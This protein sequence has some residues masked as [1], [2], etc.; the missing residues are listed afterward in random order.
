M[1]KNIYLSKTK[2]VSHSVISQCVYD[3]LSIPFCVWVGGVR[4]GQSELFVDTMGIIGRWEYG[5]KEH[6]SKMRQVMASEGLD[7]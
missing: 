1:E 5:K 4:M 6:K 3:V 2:I 7:R